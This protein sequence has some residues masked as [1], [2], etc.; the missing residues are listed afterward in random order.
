M[1]QTPDHTDCCCFH[2]ERGGGR[3]GREGGREKRGGREREERR[4][5]RRERER[6]EGGE[7]GRELICNNKI[8]C[9][10]T[11]ETESRATI[12]PQPGLY[13]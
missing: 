2:L 5:G 8:H 3:G 1:R 7:G 11:R 10:V 12:K 9:S 4:E 6:E 13:Y